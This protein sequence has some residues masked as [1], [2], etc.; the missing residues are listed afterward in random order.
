MKLL[1]YGNLG[2]EKPGILDAQ[3][4]LRDL[5]AYVSDIDGSVLN[6]ESLAKLRQLDPQQLPLV[7]GSPRIGACVNR[8]GK[9]ICIGLNFVDHAAE[10]QSKPPKQP[11]IFMK[12]SSAV[13]GPNDNIIKPLNSTKLDWEIELAMVIG[14]DG[15]YIDESSA[16]DYIAGYC[17][18][19]DVSERA[20]QLE[21]G[22]QWTKGKS[23]D[24]FGPL[25]PWLVTKDEIKDVLALDM[26]LQVNGKTY[27]QG[28]TANMIFS[29]QFIVSY[30]SQFMRLQAGDVIST[31]T[32]AG[33]GLGQKPP[34]YLKHGDELILSISGLGE[35][36]QKVVDYHL[37]NPELRKYKTI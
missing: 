30:L 19:N 31:G 13:C 28:S 26:L 36:Q 17:I 11:I 25:G 24:T 6:S 15:V 9:F 23:C 8:I 3:G 22:G 2:E 16:D 32:P 1:R 34:V 37:Q 18:C 5:S 35:Q 27:Q 29:P 4:K 7:S 14:K 21:M 33:V 20:F 12:A 10:T